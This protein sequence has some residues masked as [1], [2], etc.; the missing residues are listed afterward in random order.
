[1]P[2]AE[3]SIQPLKLKNSTKHYFKKAKIKEAIISEVQTL[4]PSFDKELK[5]YNPKKFW[6][7]KLKYN[8]INLKFI[9]NTKI[10]GYLEKM[11]VGFDIVFK[12]KTNNSNKKI[13]DKRLIQLG[14]K[15][16]NIDKP[17]LY[18]ICKILKIDIST[19]ILSNLFSYFN[20]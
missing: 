17:D 4:L 16:I 12:V 3:K 20:L 8:N 18:D 14:V 15:C 11:N 19:F 5:F 13:M 9:D 7:S 2:T 10:I 1:M 6:F